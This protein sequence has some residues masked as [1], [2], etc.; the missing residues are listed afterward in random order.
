[1]VRPR[2]FDEQQALNSAMQLFWEKGYEATSLSDLTTQMGIQR[3]SLYGAFGGKKELF[4][5]ALHKY[6]QFSLTY[7]QAKLESTSSAK[8]AI[9][10]YL[11]G[12]LDQAYGTET[13]SGCFCVNTMSELAPHDPIFEQITR[14]YQQQV[15]ALIQRKLEEGIHSGELSEDMNA[16]AAAGLIMVSSTG[17][18]VTLKSKPDRD[19]AEHVVQEILTLLR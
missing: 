7:I 1:M 9:Y 15:T 17:L 4:I 18:S 12:I 19:F 10:I 8:D 13:Y 2:E 6:I 5:T 3:P 16:E 11:N 14:K